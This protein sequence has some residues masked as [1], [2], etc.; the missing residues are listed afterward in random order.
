MERGHART[1]S[2]D[3][4]ELVVVPSSVHGANASSARVRRIGPCR[5]PMRRTRSLFIAVDDGL[6]AFLRYRL[7]LRLL[8]QGH[9]QSRGRAR[10]KTVR[11]DRAQRRY[12]DKAM[13]TTDRQSASCPI[14][15]TRS[16]E[17]GMLCNRC[18]ARSDE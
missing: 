8:P 10:V 6:S 3:A 11:A 1:V 17:R 14:A 4:F 18:L 9:A 7:M 13:A 15:S 12:M 5:Q 2:E 16:G